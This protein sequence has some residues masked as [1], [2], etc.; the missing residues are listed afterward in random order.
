MKIWRNLEKVYV[1]ISMLFMA[2]GLIPRTITEGDLNAAIQQGPSDR[3]GQLIVYSLLVPLL[4][5]HRRRILYG[6]RH[7]G[8]I[9][10]LCGLALTSLLWSYNWRFTLQRGLLL[11]IATLFA[12]YVA[13][14]FDW[15]EQL[16]LF[17]WLSLVSVVG[18]AFMAVFVPSYGFSQDMH[19]GAVKGLFPHKNMMG[20]QMAFAV[21]TMWLTKPT[22]MP[23]W[24]RVGTL[25][26]AGLLLVLSRA[27][28]ALVSLILCLVL[29][30]VIRVFQLKKPNTLPLW[31]P[32]T[33][34]CGMAAL[35]VLSNLGGLTGIIGRSATL[36]GRMPIWTAV[37]SAIGE[38]PWFGY[39]HDVF[40]SRWSVDL[41]KVNQV[42][43]FHPPHAHN[44]YLDILLGM[45]VVG[46]LVF[47]GG[48]V[49]NFLRAL[50]AFKAEDIPGARWPLF[51]LIFF[52]AFNFGES[53]ILRGLTFLWIPY[54]SI[55]VSLAM[56]AAESR[57][58]AF[59]TSPLTNEAGYEAEEGAGVSGVAPGYGV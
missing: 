48:F 57:V 13:T 23:R 36:T 22:S 37:L 19:Q 3:Y 35:F 56:M 25:M 47:L 45:G 34:I 53:N 28:T 14:C 7:S 10:A 12:I 43:G 54:V 21:L 27:E 15:E 26:G 58:A 32:L 44:G 29:Y 49:T 20:R 46:L 1:V 16:N 31:I 51:V 24:L 2:N 4:L 40:W 41:A 42:L 30:P 6:L 17:A 18:S 33:P 8:W 52:A 5:L 38:H 50:R 11:S 39:G 9:V 55:Y 59:A